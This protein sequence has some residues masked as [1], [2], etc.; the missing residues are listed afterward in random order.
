LSAARAEAGVADKLTH[1]STDEISRIEG[2]TFESG[3]FE[4]M[5]HFV[6]RISN[7]FGRLS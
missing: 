4:M 7:F 2:S 3:P 1:V 6:L 5:S